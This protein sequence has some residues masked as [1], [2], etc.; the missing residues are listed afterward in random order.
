MPIH[1]WSHVEHGVFHD[2]HQAWTIEIRNALNGG[3]LPPEFFAMAE[4]VLGGPIPDVVTLKR[5]PLPANSPQAGGG[6]AVTEAPPRARFVTSA[7]VDPYAT[8]ANRLVIKH[9]LGEVVA[10]IEIVSPGNKSGVHA[11]RSFVLK[12]A[13]LLR[14]GVNLLI[15]DLFPPSLRDPQGIH[16]A[17]WDEVCDEP[18]ELPVDKPLT[19]AA[20]NSAGVPQTAY[21]EPVAVGDPLPSLPIFLTPEIYVPAPLEATY[22]ATWTRCPEVL[23]D[24]VLNAGSERD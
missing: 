7:E 13:E 23:K 8:K 10:V 12:A 22:E 5:V 14:S 6:V 21:V 18:F 11:L 4:Q 3:G 24:E 9:R 19:V 15:V 2:F 20:Y 16:K 1:D 17:I